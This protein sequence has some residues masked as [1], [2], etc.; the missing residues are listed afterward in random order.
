MPTSS[1]R[2]EARAHAYFEAATALDTFASTTND[3]LESEEFELVANRLW[4]EYDRLIE[5]AKKR[6]EKEQAYE[7]RRKPEG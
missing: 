7:H 1:E 6:Q 4:P 2:L 3:P 5:L